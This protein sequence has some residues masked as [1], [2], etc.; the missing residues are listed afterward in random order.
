[1][2]FGYL[3]LGYVITYFLS[4]TAGAIGIA[5]LALL[6]GSLLMFWGLRGLC[7]FHLS[8]VPAKW[9]TL[10]LFALGLCRLWQDTAG[11]WFG[12]GGHAADVMTTVI[13]WV[14]FAATLLFHFAMLY[15]VRV[16]ALEVGLNK[17][18]SHA[19]YNTLAVGIWAALYL[20]CNMPSVGERV[21][22]YLGFSMSLFNF[23]YLISTI[24]LLVRCTKNIC[25]EGDED[26]PL[27]PS[28]FAWVNR[29]GEA[30]SQMMDKLKSN[31]RADG[32]AFWHKHMEKKPQENTTKKQHKKKKKK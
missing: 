14:S 6:I 21:L 10:P 1:M 23:A 18:S 28:R 16:L 13:T 11:A 12:W 17:L 20:L 31:S 2:G 22:P 5:W 9:L 8:F 3:L 19:M 7:R 15:A 26:V 25:A 32:D 24:V 29:M 4:I 27:K 30:Y